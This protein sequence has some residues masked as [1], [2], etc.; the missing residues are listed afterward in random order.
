MQLHLCYVYPLKGPVDAV[1][2]RWWTATGREGKSRTSSHSPG[3]DPGTHYSQ[4]ITDIFRA[5]IILTC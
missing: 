1:G 2:L 3:P 5:V 4:H